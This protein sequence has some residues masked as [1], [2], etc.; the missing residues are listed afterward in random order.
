MPDDTNSEQEALGATS[1][2]R[3]VRSATRQRRGR[4]GRPRGGRTAAPGR[5]TRQTARIP[6]DEPSAEGIVTVQSGHLEHIGQMGQSQCFDQ[7][8]ICL[9]YIPPTQIT[10]FPKYSQN[11]MPL[12]KLKL[13]SRLSTMC[14]QLSK[15]RLSQSQPKTMPKA[16][17]T[18]QSPALMLY[19]IMDYVPPTYLVHCSKR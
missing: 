13:C 18:F 9:S 12:L 16:Q 14:P 3:S 7:T 10:L 4:G 6:H 11:K 5:Q 17:R 15:H 19:P 8:T 1:S 2:Q